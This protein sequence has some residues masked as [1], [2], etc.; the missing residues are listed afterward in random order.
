MEVVRPR[1]TY[2][3]RPRKLSTYRR[4]ARTFETMWV[5]GF[6]Q[7]RLYYCLHPRVSQRSTREEETPAV[8]V[9]RKSEARSTS[10]RL[11]NE[12]IRKLMSSSYRQVI[13]RWRETSC[14]VLSEYLFL[15][16]NRGGRRFCQ[17]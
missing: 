1:G 2:V 4:R 8:V 5:V 6:T 11:P 7:P 9:A 14:F 12:G 17:V 13:S 10:S 3:S 15:V 16:R